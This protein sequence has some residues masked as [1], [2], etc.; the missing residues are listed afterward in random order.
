MSNL[1][2]E[3]LAQ[4]GFS[5]AMM[6][7]GGVMY[8]AWTAA[9]VCIIVSCH[10]QKTYGVPWAF[11][12]FNVIWEFCFSFNVLDQRLF[13]FFLWGNRLWL[14]FDIVIA[15][16]FLAYGR[17]VQVQPF[18]KRHFHEVALGTFLLNAVGLATFTPFFNEFT[19][20]ASSMM[21]NFGMSLLYIFMVFDRPDLRGLSYPAAWLKM[22]GTGAGSV[23][24]YHWLPAQFADGHMITHPDV[25]TPRTYS[26]MHFLYVSIF[27]I[28][29]LYIAL[30]TRRRRELRRAG[31]LAEPSQVCRIIPGAAVSLV[32]AGLVLLLAG[33]GTRLLAAESGSDAGA[34]GA[35]P[36]PEV[37]DRLRDLDL[38][39]LVATVASKKAERVFDTP[40]AVTVL[41]DEEIRR[42]GVRTVPDALRLVPGMEVARIN[43]S[44]WA[45]SSRGFNDRFANKLLVLQDGR[46][47]YS[48][49]FNGVYWDMVN[50][51]LED[52]D[53]IEVVRGPGGS[54]WGANAV[55]GV[56]NI[57]TKDAHDTLGT[58][59][60]GGGGPYDAFAESRYGQRL[61]ETGAWRAYV[62]YDWHDELPLGEGTNFDRHDNLSGGFRSDWDA[63]DDRFTLQ[64]DYQYGNRNQPIYETSYAPPYANLVE[65]EFVTRAGNALF[66]WTHLF[67]DG[68]DLRLQGYYDHMDRGANSFALRYDVGDVDF[69]HRLLLPLRQ[70]LIYGAGYRVYHDKAGNYGRDF[71]QQPARATLDYVSAFVRDEIGL[72]EDTLKLIVGSRFEY[73][74]FTGFEIQPDARM[75]W[76]ANSDHTVWTGVSRAVRTPSRAHEDLTALQPLP[77]GL[78]RY[79]G[80]PGI[81]SEE[82]LSFQTGWRMRFSKAAGVDL[83]GY[84]SLYDTMD[85]SWVGTPRVEATPAPPHLIVPVQT[86]NAGQVDTYGFE[87]AADYSPL[88]SWQLRAGYSYFDY[89]HQ[90]KV[91]FDNAATPHHQVFARSS[92]DL[93]GDLQFDL[94]YRIRS[95]L[96]LYGLKAFAELDARLAWRPRSWVEVSVV[97][98]N[99]FHEQ[100][101]EFGIPPFNIAA[102]VSEVPRTF[103]LQAAFRF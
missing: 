57:I 4:P 96:E 23:F 35:L 67:E 11:L 92:V 36:S 60:A 80:N 62:K 22:I 89:A 79:T 37:V 17:A 88:E 95:D 82:V 59:A 52:V 49:Q 2:S 38:E 81:E 15:V 41:S 30:L 54:L 6:V 56:V 63:G 46:A 71:V 86:V 40:A 61:G 19:G 25:P 26:F 90:E 10:R 77:I 103:Y 9:Y 99:L 1:L 24:L 73:N 28:D 58:Y 74:D 31:G 5:P 32:G 3:I 91:Q 20:A 33:G 87:L 44:Q 27:L 48:P 65:E 47:L 102:P 8:L 75:L 18:L 21:M 68:T 78:A 29:C 100:R 34:T 101:K 72:V 50:P 53:Q 12:I 69:Q 7:V 83:S 94:W 39:S 42:S 93:P 76:L 43:G 98:Q 97:G 66:R 85:S 51:I 64:G 55:N 84:Y 70:E 13:W 45:V 14:V 16:Q